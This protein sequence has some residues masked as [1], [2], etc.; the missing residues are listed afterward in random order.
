[1]LHKMRGFQDKVFDQGQQSLGNIQMTGQ[2]LIVKKTTNV[3]TPI[4]APATNNNQDE[5]ADI[6]F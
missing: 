1:M 2:P 3:V 5:I 6:E 4:I